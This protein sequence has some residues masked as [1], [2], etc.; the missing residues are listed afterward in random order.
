MAGRKITDER[1][2]R[3]ALDSIGRTGLELVAWCRARDIDARSLAGWRGVLEE[4]GYQ[5][6]AVGFV[7]L[8]PPKRHDVPP[9]PLRVTCGAF[10]VEV[11][12]D[13]DE[14]LLERLLRVVAAC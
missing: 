12:A 5:S 14:M 1:E 13:F 11:A 2:A 4:R 7:E 9:S 10:A 6:P 3:E 8:V